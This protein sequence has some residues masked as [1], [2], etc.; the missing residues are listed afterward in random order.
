MRGFVRVDVR[1]PIA[2]GGLAVAGGTRG[3]AA[4]ALEGGGNMASSPDIGRFATRVGG[5]GTCAASNVVLE[6]GGAAV[7]ATLGFFALF[8][9]FLRVILGTGSVNSDV[10]AA[11]GSHD[12]PLSLQA[13]VQITYEHRE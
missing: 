10:G 7:A 3:V 6:E 5:T 12:P 11:S 13:N 2:A 1:A 4:T 8:D 9:F